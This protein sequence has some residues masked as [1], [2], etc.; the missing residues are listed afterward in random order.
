[1]YDPRMLSKKRDSFLGLLL[2]LVIFLQ[3]IMPFL[4]AHTGFSSESGFHTPDA[5]VIHA[6]VHKSTILELTTKSVDE[7]YAVQIGSG[8]SNE[9][10]KFDLIH[11]FVRAI[12]WSATK[13]NETTLLTTFQ[14]E[15]NKA[16][17]SFYRSE[18]YPPPSLAPPTQHS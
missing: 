7:S 9:V 15:S 14:P 4:H 2:L 5:S 8:L 16:R 17:S 11:F 3:G 1:M 10:E 6:Q 12:F 13:S 18:A